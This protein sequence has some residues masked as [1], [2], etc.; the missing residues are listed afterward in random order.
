MAQGLSRFSLA[1]M[2]PPRT[3]KS[4]KESN[5]MSGRRRAT[6]VRAQSLSHVRLCIPM[7]HSPPGSSVHGIILDMGCHLFLQGIFQT[8]G[9]NPHLLHCRQILYHW[10]TREAQRRPTRTKIQGFQT[11]RNKGESPTDA[12]QSRDTDW[13]E[14]SDVKRER[15]SA[16]EG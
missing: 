3:T 1:D 13:V 14:Y 10:V 7:D 2:G 15:K 16:P 8:Q 12:S 9:S 11:E 5:E 4:L 6:C